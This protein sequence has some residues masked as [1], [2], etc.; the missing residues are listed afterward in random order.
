MTIELDEAR[1][2]QRATILREVG[3]SA[4]SPASDAPIAVNLPSASEQRELIAELVAPQELPRSSLAPPAGAQAAAPDLPE[5]D[6]F[7][8]HLVIGR[9]RE[10]RLELTLVQ[11]DITEVDADCYVV[12]L[13]K[14][15]APDGAASALDRAMGGRISDLVARR[16]FSAEVGEVSILPNGRRVMHAPNIA[17]V[18]LGSIDAF[19]AETLAL[20]GENIARTFVAAG[21]DDVAIVPFGGASGVKGVDMLRNLVR[22]F[23]AGLAD[24]DGEFRFRSLIICERD[25]ERFAFINETLRARS[26]TTLFDGIELTLREVH[27]PQRTP[28]VRSAAPPTTER[29]YLLVRE[30][31]ESEA[32]DERLPPLV[33]SLLTSGDKAMI[34]SGV[35]PSTP[36]AL[37][38]HLGGLSGFANLADPAAETY[39]D[40]LG[41]LVL[42]PSL[43]MA[44]KS[45]KDQHLVVV[46]DAGSSRIPWETL[47]IDGVFPAL[48]GGLSHRYEAPNLSVA[49]WFER[50]QQSDRLSVLLVVDPTG[51]L[52]G[53][54]RE[55]ERIRT[56]FHKLGSSA[57]L[58][59]M[60]HDKAR[61]NE[62]KEC[63]SSGAFDVVH[64]A[65]HAFFDPEQPA[66]SG[67]LCAGREV[68]S[69]LDLASVG[70]LPMLMF[71]NAC[72]A[73]RVRGEPVQR[74]ETPPVSE[75]VRR[76]IGFAEALLRGG[77]ANFIGTYWPVHDNPAEIFA[78]HF[79]ERLLA[80]ANLNDAVRESRRAV[81]ESDRRPRFQDWADYVFYG[82]PDF[83]LKLRSDEQPR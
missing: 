1:P 3:E 67:L 18:G 57:V 53:A 78:T 64:Y 48:A 68:L 14:A 13:F 71:F 56:L 69:G 54:R 32:D 12:G 49:K 66:R 51:D 36:E 28:D 44:L 76:G 74:T 38:A 2:R 62:L 39:G 82:D 21:L 22:G 52:E 65:G 16:M 23:L 15:V 81:H 61:K 83:R 34:L 43:T 31:A 7:S 79:Y 37:D 77:I 55:G 30:T 20:V 50:R 47:R 45:Y 5:Q 35:Q 17:F 11:G 40:K 73:A 42:A 75:V 27:L 24:S 6:P 60:W 26:H 70:S 19:S 58:T 8:P 41:E 59:E 9:G 46:H 29:I 63:F 72:E 10:R 4:T 80:G 25:P 33:A